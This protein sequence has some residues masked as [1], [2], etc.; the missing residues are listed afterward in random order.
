MAEK[1]DVA[2]IGGGIAGLTAGLYAARLGLTTIVLERM[3]AGGQVINIEK[4]ENYPGFPE[5]V[6]GADLGASIQEQA[7]HAGADVRFTEVEGLKLGESYRVV[8]T[9]DGL[10]EAKTVIIASGSSLRKLGVP[11]EEEFFGRGVSQCASCDGNFF[12]NLPVAVVGGG[13]SALDEALVLT[14]YASKVTVLHRGKQFRAQGALQ[15][16]IL[17]HPKVEVRWN[18]VLEEILGQEEVKGIRVKDVAAGKATEE[19][20]SGVFVFVGLEPNTKFLKGVVPLDGAG[21][22][23]VN[24]WMETT[25]PGV[26]AAGDLRQHSARQLASSAGDGA[27]AAIA[28]GRYISSRSWPG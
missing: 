12:A 3:M 22:I 11:G 4:L 5:G 6:P 25:V 20:V 17:G 9:S 23:P 28:A 13:D 27:T 2:I 10:L 24:L 19:Q 8:E 7:S 18:T 1:C 15:R 21:H 16:E 14:N 26:L